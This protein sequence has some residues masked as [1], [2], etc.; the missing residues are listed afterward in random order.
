MVFNIEYG[1]T[2]IDFDTVVA[3][4]RLAGAEV[5]AIEEAYGNTDRLAAALGWA[6]VDRRT[7]IISQLP[8]VA[9]RGK[10]GTALTLVEVSPGCVVAVGN[11]HLPSDPVVDTLISQGKHDEI[12]AIEHASRLPPLQMVLQDLRT[13][14][15]AGMPTFLAGDFNARSHLDDS[16]PWPTSLALEAAGFH[17]SYRETHRDAQAHPGFTWWAGRP[18]VA[19]WNPTLQ[20][21]QQR[22]DYLH[23]A[24]PAQ[25]KA[26]WIVGERG[27]RDVDLA[28][29]PWVSDHRA[30]VS[31]FETMPAPMSAVVTV[32]HQRV[33]SGKDIPVQWN[34]HSGA[35]T[36]V[37]SRVE[38]DQARTVVSTWPVDTSSTLMS[39]NV[40]SHGLAPG[41][42]EVLLRNGERAAEASAPF[43]ITAPGAVPSV[44][45]ALPIF[46]TGHPLTVRWDNAPGN[47][48]DWIGVYPDSANPGDTSPL[49]WRG[50]E[51][52][53]GGSMVLD[54]TVEGG[55]WPLAPGRYR[56]VL[57]LD[58]SYVVLAES[59]FTITR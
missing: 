53:I 1:G 40:A 52:L 47:R 14:A 8:I 12:L 46:Q 42:Y 41:E 16:F 44:G 38:P 28:I 37:V 33:V 34:T 43:W 22:I 39:R 6:N 9:I 31:T 49:L 3:A 10:R 19:G 5:V 25:A 51:A 13:F 7:Q 2:L 20:D 59:A 18:K 30:V 21:P 54:Q 55:G 4:I 29:E 27:G 24:G 32:A 48:W 45:T 36:V 35:A 23:S 58:D 50:T 26:S 11:V 15:D 56:V 57:S 17:D